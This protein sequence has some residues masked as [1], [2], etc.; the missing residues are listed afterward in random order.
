MQ[1]STI[2][3][4]KESL[5]SWEEMKRDGGP[6]EVFADEM[7][8]EFKGKI[9]LLEFLIAEFGKFGFG[10]TL[11]HETQEMWGIIVPDASHPGKVRW[12]G[13]RKDGFTG[14]STY[15]TAEQC[16]GDMLDSGLV[17]PD[18]GALDRLSCTLEWARGMEIVDLVQAVNSARI[19][20]NEF[21]EKREEIN[22]RYSRLT[23]A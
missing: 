10:M 21:L 2:E 14:H 8:T 17:M 15:E 9:H 22:A 6:F 23:A 11:R 13:F 4:L 3:S 20:Y 5:V 7:I 18:Q 19:S 1:P 16:I 12:S